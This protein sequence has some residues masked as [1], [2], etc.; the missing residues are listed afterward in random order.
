MRQQNL[1]ILLE[2][3]GA[4]LR[5]VE[6]AL[7][8][9]AAFAEGVLGVG[10]S[11]LPP[12]TAGLVL[13]SRI[14]RN[15]QTY[16]NYVSAIRMACQVAGLSTQGLYGT[17]VRRAQQAIARRTPPQ[18]PKEFIQA[19]LLRK[20]CRLASQEGSLLFALCSFRFGHASQVTDTVQHSTHF[21]T[22]F[23]SV[24]GLKLCRSLLAQRSNCAN[25]WARSNVC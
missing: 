1:G 2:S 8:C 14:F 5:T 6:S 25:H 9:W 24:R 11:H 10:A 23:F 12:T 20:L 16:A 21:A 18:D 3:A 13:F 17:E 15:A 19:P 4:S 7:R 22:A